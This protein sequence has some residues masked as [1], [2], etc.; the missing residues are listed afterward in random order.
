M[1]ALRYSQ[2]HPRRSSSNSSI[3]AQLAHRQKQAIGIVAAQLVNARDSLVLDS[4]STVLEAVRALITRAIPFTAVTNG[5]EIALLCSHAPE[6]RVMLPGG[7]IRPGS[8]SVVGEPGVEFLKGI[9]ADVCLIG[10]HGITDNVLTEA[11]PEI[12]FVK[13]AMIQAS[14]RRILL[15]DSS[16]FGANALIT[17]A[18]LSDMD[19]IV[20]DDGISAEQLSSL[21]AMKLKVTVVPSEMALDVEAASVEAAND[22]QP[23]PSQRRP[24]R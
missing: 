23:Q 17:F 2:S 13:R 9:H 18:N 5:L 19:E 24:Q 20:T 8:S 11:S 1:A 14:R 12:A 22:G 7:T 3:N 6:V 15:T 10:T 16:K 21:E 4:S